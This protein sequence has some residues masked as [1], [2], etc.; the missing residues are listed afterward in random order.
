MEIIRSLLFV[1]ADSQKKIE[2]ARS[3]RP[4]G[5]ILDLEDGVAPGNK[6]LA[7]TVL[8]SE[9]E[10]LV[11][12]PNK[13]L[14]RVNSFQTQLLQ[15]DLRIAVVPAVHGIVLPKSEDESEI[16]HADE[17]ITRLERENGLTVGQIRLLLMI[18]GPV[19][20]VNAYSLACSSRRVRA[21]IF[22]AEDYCAEMVVSRTKSGEE[23]AYARS[24]I[25]HAARAAGLE[26][27]DT[28]FK[29]L[30]DDAGFLE[31]TRRVKQMGFTGKLLIHPG[32][33]NLV[34]KGFAPQNH[35][36]VWAE[37]VIEA[38]EAAQQES[39]GLAVVDGQMVDRPIVLQAKR[40]LQHKEDRL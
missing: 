7:R 38:F 11:E 20:V 35:E 9:L 26:A 3:L 4:D 33:I 25:T 5:L 34:H 40:I 2:K 19:G 36:I 18:E 32:Q 37:R 6:L 17:V 27:I 22:G 30:T 24:V 15:D 23:I 14:V 39:S 31:E 28:V 16:S 29:D 13:I 1:P 8:S 12:V 21:L 10:R